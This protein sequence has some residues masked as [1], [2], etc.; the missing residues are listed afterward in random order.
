M[1]DNLL[2]IWNTPADV[3]LAPLK[4]AFGVEQEQVQSKLPFS[5][6]YLRSYQFI[7]LTCSGLSILST[8][9]KA[10]SYGAYQ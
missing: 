2:K 1:S 3:K 4:H 9:F 7:I 6:S 5:S 10:I 8:V